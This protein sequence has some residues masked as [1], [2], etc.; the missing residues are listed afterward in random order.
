M[1]EAQIDAG[2]HDDFSVADAGIAVKE[3]GVPKARKQG[4]LTGERLG[5]AVDFGRGEDT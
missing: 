4:E 3:A 1:F 2:S 5:C